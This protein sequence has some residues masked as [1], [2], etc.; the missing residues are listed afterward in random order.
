M[1]SQQSVA[2]ELPAKLGSKSSVLRSGTPEEPG[3]PFPTAGQCPPTPLSS[4]PLPLGSS[5]SDSL[6]R[7][8]ST[9]HRFDSCPYL[10]SVVP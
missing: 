2:Q 5:S 1:P 9:Q 3:P 10:K 6:A 7:L 4:H 8:S